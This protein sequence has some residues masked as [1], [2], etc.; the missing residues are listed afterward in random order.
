MLKARAIIEVIGYPQDYVDRVINNVSDKLKGEEGI[1]IINSEIAPAEKVK[2]KM[3][4]SFIEAEIEFESFARFSYFCFDYMPSSIE[5]LNYDKNK[6]DSRQLT[7]G[8]NDMLGRLHQFNVTL[9][10]LTS[11]NKKLKAKLEND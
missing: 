7:I 4:A 8:L 2:D 9:A 5:I 6:L 10:A 1:K 11:Q 3:S